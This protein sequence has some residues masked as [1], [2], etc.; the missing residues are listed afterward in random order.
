MIAV[1]CPLSRLVIGGEGT[2]DPQD[3]GRYQGGLDPG[4]DAPDGL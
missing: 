4:G 2:R 3:S 1:A